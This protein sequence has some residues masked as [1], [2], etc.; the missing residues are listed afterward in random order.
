MKKFIVIA[1]WKMYKTID[2]ACATYL[3][4]T[5]KVR[6]YSLL[7]K[8]DIVI[9]SPS[10]YIYSLYNKSLEENNGILL[11]AQNCSVESFGAYTG[12]V[13]AP[14]LKSI[15]AEYVIVGHS[16]SRKYFNETD[17]DINKKITMA[18]KY[19]IKPI[20]CVG[21]P[22]EVRNLGRHIDFVVNQLNMALENLS[23]IQRKGLIIAYEPLWAIGTNNSASS[24]DAENMHVAIRLWMASKYGNELASS[25]RIVY[26]G[27]VSPD[28]IASLSKEPNIDGVLVGGASLDPDKFFQ[29]IELYSKR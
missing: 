11:A 16:E 21:E 29:I 25:L 7:D 23:D 24:A 13:S 5:K 9:A 22:I 6:P 10:P 20:L 4:I 28:N 3:E 14:M 1:N 15:G 8:I 26:G 12:D 19:N 18:I 17:S 27:S 2:E